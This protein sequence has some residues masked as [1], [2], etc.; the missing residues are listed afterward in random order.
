MAALIGG[1]RTRAAAGL[2]AVGLGALQRVYRATLRGAWRRFVAAARDPQRAQAARLQTILRDNAG[3]EYGKAQGFDGLGSVAE[4]QARVPR[5]T[6]RALTGCVERIAAGETGVLTTAPVRMLERTSGSTAPNRLVPYTDGLLAEFGAATGAWLYDLLTRAPGLQ[7]TRSYWSVSPATR[8]DERSPGGLPIGFA[9]DTEYFGPLAGWA[10]RR[11]L[12]VPPAVARRRRMARWRWETARSLLAADDLGLISVW[13]PSFL[14]LLHRY[15]AEHWELLLS[16]LPTARASAL[17]ATFSGRGPGPSGDALWPR[18]AL[19]SCWT[20]GSAA[21]L[22]PE[23]RRRFPCTP[24]QPKGLLATEG[25]V[26]F[27]VWGQPAPVAALTGH[28][29]EFIDLDHPERR[30]LGA[31][32]LRAGGSYSPL[33]TTSGG[34]YRYH[35]AD[36]VD[37]VGHLALAPLLRFAGRLDRVSD[38][39]GEKLSASNVQAALDAV[40]RRHGVRADFA[41]LAPRSGADP[42]AYALLLQTPAPDAAIARLAGALD[43]A[44]AAGHHYAYCRSLG[45]LGPL[46]VLRVREGLRGYQRRLQEEGQRAGDIKP[47]VLDARPGWDQ[48]LDARPVLEG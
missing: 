47:T 42:P 39:C 4:Y 28:F 2:R 16:A 21:A 14:I 44:L 45:Q 18:L 25:V 37:C 23:L 35:L 12:A 6:G 27:P 20:D 13:S 36:R 24:L 26:S 15:I 40:L 30:P 5:S 46:E 32:E 17:R 31:H 29:L 7:G 9:D 38:L 3:C 8:Q 34:L 41:L 11:M 10:L 1:R 33:L 22:L 19:I 48:A 43:D